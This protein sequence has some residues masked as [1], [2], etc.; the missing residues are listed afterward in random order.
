MDTKT[1]T[2]EIV[3]HLPAKWQAF[4]QSARAQSPESLVGINPE[5][6]HGATLALLADLAE[7]HRALT[8]SVTLQSHYAKLLNAYDAGNRMEFTAETW[9]ARVKEL[10]GE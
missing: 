8:R 4:A 6:L 2:P 10:E 1:L 7:A 5:T 3:R 9:L